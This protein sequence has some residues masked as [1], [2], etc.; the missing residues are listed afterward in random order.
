MELYTIDQD[1]L[2]IKLIKSTPLEFNLKFWVHISDDILML[3][4]DGLYLYFD[5]TTFEHIKTFQTYS[6]PFLLS[7]GSVVN[8]YMEGYY[9]LDTKT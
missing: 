1:K 6:E 9:L 4:K 7:N 2:T 5:A 8:F 3:S